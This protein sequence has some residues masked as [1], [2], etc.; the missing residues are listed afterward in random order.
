MKPFERHALVLV[1]FPFTDR[2]SQ[3]RRPALVLSAPDFQRTSGHVLLAMV[4]SAKQSAWPLDWTIQNHQA[5]GLP[6]PCLVRFKLFTLDERLIL[7]SLGHLAQA[8]R[9]GVAA[10]LG[11][12]VGLHT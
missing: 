12:L 3:K 1:P 11:Q 4:T 8:D 5:A 10:Q 9:D 7:K 2:A 6:Q